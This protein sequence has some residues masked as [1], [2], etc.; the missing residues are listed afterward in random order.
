[1][2]PARIESP[3]SRLPLYAQVEDALVAR[4]ASGA[5][6][7]GAQLPTEEELIREFNVSRTTI[8]ATIQNLLR[9]GLVEIRRGRGTFVASPRIVQE[10]TELTGFV[11]DMRV[12]GRVPSA[13][14]LSREAV[15]ASPLVADKLAAPAGVTVIR[16]QRVRLS[17]GAPLS[18]DE[19]Y[20]PED[21]GR[22]VMTDDLER[23]PIFTLLEERYDTPLVEAEYVLEA[24]AAEP[25]VA[26]ALEIAVGAPVFVI[27]RTS[28]TSG[29]RP[30][31]YERLHYRGDAIRFRTRLARRRVSQ[32]AKRD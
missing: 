26:M 9:R 13:R 15:P 19:T 29:H 7:V 5:L 3:S 27:E 24:A 23:Q 20:L 10:L 6:P 18:F 25:A 1:M 2:A 12:L 4:I 16:I 11:E 14:V 21:L 30:V 22:K 17:D 8:R 31:D 32:A 28:Y